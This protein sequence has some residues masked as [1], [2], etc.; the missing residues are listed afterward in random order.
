MTY[1]GDR[2][3]LIRSHARR[4]DEALAEYRPVKSAASIDGLPV[5]G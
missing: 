5:F 2:D 1:E 3:L 4:D